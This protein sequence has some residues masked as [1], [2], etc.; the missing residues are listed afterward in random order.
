MTDRDN[1]WHAPRHMQKAMAGKDLALSIGQQKL[2]GEI[3]ENAD[4]ICTLINKAIQNLG[5]CTVHRN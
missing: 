3:G 4:P 1:H 5:V 2:L